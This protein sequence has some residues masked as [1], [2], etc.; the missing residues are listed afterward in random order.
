MRTPGLICGCFLIASSCGF[1]AASDERASYYL[2]GMQS[3]FEAVVCGEFLST[4]KMVDSNDGLVTEQCHVTFDSTI[5]S[6]AGH[7]LVKAPEG[8]RA[9]YI[10][11]EAEVLYT[12]FRTAIPTVSRFRRAQ[13]IP[14]S[15]I[16]PV[17]IFCATI[18]GKG[19]IVSRMRWQ[20]IVDE[21]LHR[22]GKVV[23]ES[24]DEVTIEY[25][26]QPS[27]EST[28]ETK[29]SV[30]L[31]PEHFYPLSAQMGYREVGSD[32]WLQTS[33]TSSTWAKV[34]GV[35]V[36]LSIDVKESFKNRNSS[37]SVL[38]DWQTVNKPVDAATFTLANP[39]IPS[40]ARVANFELQKP[41]DE[42]SVAELLGKSVSVEAQPDSLK[43]NQ[44][45]SLF[46]FGNIT[47]LLV[48]IV[49]ALARRGRWML[50]HRPKEG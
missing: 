39:I 35:Y 36:P 15:G 28:V 46:V 22:E 44:S 18:G 13:K 26:Q 27:K 24:S 41:F 33:L 2:N 7:W 9:L 11:N 34:E 42:G 25:V 38:L 50:F 47:V 31:H 20:Q 43:N 45:R 10:E 17:D 48:V 6:V 14:M 1:V 21:M 19:A 30:K 37:V 12:Q 49:V 29:W 32:D 23:T 3:C 5:D 4:C 16:A 8:D 40:H